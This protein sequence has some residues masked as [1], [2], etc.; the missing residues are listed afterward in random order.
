MYYIGY[1]DQ[2][3]ENDGY[4]GSGLY[5]K[6]AIKKYGKENFSRSIIDSFDNSDDAFALEIELIDS[7]DPMSYNIADGGQ[8]RSGPHSEE[9][10]RKISEGK[11]NS[12]YVQTDE[13]RRKISIA[14][15]GGKRTEA[16]KKKMSDSAKRVCKNRNYT[17]KNNP[18]AG[19]KPK[20]E[21]PHCGAIGAGSVMKRW[22][23][24]RC[25]LA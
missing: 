12:S 20:V 3:D 10:K 21:C 18:Y 15:I 6:R 5:L 22:H 24:D 8:G 13:H 11:K 17:G 23:F 7:S 1:H 19:T 25:N 14:Q 16:T 2:I 9:T 4:L